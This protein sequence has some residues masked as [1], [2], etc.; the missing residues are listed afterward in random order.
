MLI[1][2]KMKNK[3]AGASIIIGV[4]IIFLLIFGG[5]YL[6]LNIN[7]VKAN[8][9]NTE[10]IPEEEEKIGIEKVI[11]VD[12]VQCSEDIECEDEDECTIN[13]CNE[14]I[15]MLNQATLCYNNDNCCPEGCNSKNDNDCL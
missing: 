2:F 8:S 1:D 10:E 13:H 14:G 3:K 9:E 11:E 12:L 15:C 6:V 5:V 4:V 7:P